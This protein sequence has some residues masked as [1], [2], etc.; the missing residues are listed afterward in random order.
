M[1]EVFCRQAFFSSISA[2]KKRLSNFSHEACY[3]NLLKT[4]DPAQA[5]LT[6]FFDAAKGPL[7]GHF[8]H[9]C[10]DYPIIE[11]EKGTEAGSFLYLLEHVRSLDLDPDTIL[12]F[13]EDDYLHRKGWLSILKE[14]FAL[15]GID[16][17]TLYDHKDKYFLYPRLQSKIFATSSCH[18]RTTPSTTN[19][20][21]VRFKTLMEDFSI[22]RKYS[23]RGPITADHDKFLCLQNRGRVLI[24]SIPGWS[25]HAEPEFAS[26]CVN[27]D[28]I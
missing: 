11:F 8:L 28:H 10:K 18:W 21:A 13:V 22:H 6:F 14:A 16:Y 25:T 5:R 23:S 19:T 17:A 9:R 24:S 12:Y 3:L 20:F 1:I 2:H 15:P 26:P 4:L 7:S 27:W